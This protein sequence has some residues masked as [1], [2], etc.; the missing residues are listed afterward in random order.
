MRKFLDSDRRNFDGTLRDFVP[1]RILVDVR[2]SLKQ[3]MRMKRSEWE[4]FL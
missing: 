4:F 2:H 1:I 3:K